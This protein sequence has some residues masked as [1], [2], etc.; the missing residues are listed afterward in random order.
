MATLTG[1]PF[2]DIMD[3]ELLQPLGMHRTG[4]AYTEEVSRRAA[5]GYH[6][7]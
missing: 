1:G 3:R 7:R 2:A 5:T 4:F 6:P